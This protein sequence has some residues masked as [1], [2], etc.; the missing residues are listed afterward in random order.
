MS[1]EK[2]EAARIFKFNRGHLFLGGER[3]L[4]L[5]TGTLTLVLVVILQ[6]KIAAI[7]GIVLWLSSMPVF[8]MMARYD[9][10]MSQIYQRY[11]RHQRFYPA[12]SMKL[13]RWKKDAKT[14]KPSR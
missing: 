14:R 8:R 7:I 5:A 13:L 1:E 2:L 10:V 4:V 11:V 6:D 12:H 3:P 9:P